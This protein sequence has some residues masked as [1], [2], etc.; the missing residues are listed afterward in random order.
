MKRRLW[1][2]LALTDLV[3]LATDTAARTQFQS[4]TSMLSK[5]FSQTNWFYE[6]NKS[7]SLNDLSMIIKAS[8]VVSI[9]VELLSND[10]AS[11]W[12]AHNAYWAI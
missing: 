8:P 5:T 11:P 7:N 3:R 2:I 4:M 10:S 12:E 1:L 6:Y 9:G